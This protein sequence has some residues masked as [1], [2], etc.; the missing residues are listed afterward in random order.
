MLRPDASSAAIAAERSDPAPS[1]LCASGAPR[2]SEQLPDKLADLE[3]AGIAIAHGVQL[4]THNIGDFQ[5][6]GLDPSIPG[7]SNK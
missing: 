4:A 7:A 1:E 3:T 5:G 6:L 2:N